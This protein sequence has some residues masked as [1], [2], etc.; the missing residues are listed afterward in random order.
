MCFKLSFGLR[1]VWIVFRVVFWIRCRCVFYLSFELCVSALTV[2]VFW[3]SFDC[4]LNCLLNVSLPIICWTSLSSDCRSNCLWRCLLIV[5]V[6]RRRV[7][8]SFV[9]WMSLPSDRV[10][11]CLLNCLGLS[12]ESVVLEVASALCLLTVFWRVCSRLRRLHVYWSLRAVAHVFAY[13]GAFSQTSTKRTNPHNRK[14]VCR[15][16]EN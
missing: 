10:F 4:L 12:F 11:H 14:H 3:S 5:Y 1:V 2:F 16:L 6:Y 15:V 9:C 13:N 8:M 7:L